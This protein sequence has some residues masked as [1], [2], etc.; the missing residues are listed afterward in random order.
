MILKKCICFLKL[1]TNQSKI[2][3]DIKKKEF[4][5]NFSSVKSHILFEK[6]SNNKIFFT[7]SNKN[8]RYKY[9]LNF[10]VEKKQH[11]LRDQF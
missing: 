9:A 11:S 10:L 2:N 7:F 1:D 3:I 4:Y 5:F 8:L 6:V